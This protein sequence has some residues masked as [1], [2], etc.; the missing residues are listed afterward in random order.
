ML[1]LNVKTG[2]EKLKIEASFRLFFHSLSKKQA[3]SGLKHIMQ[4]YFSN[5]NLDVAIRLIPTI[6]NVIA[7]GLVRSPRI[8]PF[9][10]K[11]APVSANSSPTTN[12]TC[13]RFTIVTYFIL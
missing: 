12:N 4:F 1:V 2:D 8:Q 11:N 7:A 5:R 6:P 3:S 13:S 9:H 10:I